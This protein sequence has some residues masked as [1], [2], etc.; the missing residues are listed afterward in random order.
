MKIYEDEPKPSEAQYYI[1]GFTGPE[2]TNYCPI[3]EYNEQDSNNNIYMGH[4]S[5][6]SSANTEFGEN[7]YNLHIK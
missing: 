1:T 3:S 5:Y 4:C 6:E 7:S 2:K